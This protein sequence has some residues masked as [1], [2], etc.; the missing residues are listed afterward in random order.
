MAIVPHILNAS[1]KFDA[2]LDVLSAQI[3][4]AARTVSQHLSLDADVCVVHDPAYCNPLLGIG[5][6]AFS[7]NLMHVN[8]DV[9][10]ENFERAIQV[11][12]LSV[13]AHEAHHCKRMAAIPTDSSLLDSIVTEGLA[14]QFEL[15][16]A[17]GE[18]P[19]FIPD[20]VMALT[21]EL[22]SRMRATLE[23]TDYCYDTYFLGKDTDIYPKY[24]GFAVGFDI[25][26]SFLRREGLTAG[27]AA[28][29]PAQEFLPI[30]RSRSRS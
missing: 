20:V 16:V 9:D 8:V 5:G 1:G 19:S 12:L 30:A 15:Q 18:K 2:H 28:W 27:E 4:I 10:H 21:D 25:V 26:G 13:L 23:L 3:S 6:L 17:G 29:V 22:L 14:C 7:P 11:E 24:A